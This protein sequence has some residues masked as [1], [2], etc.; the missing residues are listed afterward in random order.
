M[1][2][3]FLTILTISRK[4]NREPMKKF[5]LENG[6]KPKPHCPFYFDY[7]EER[8]DSENDGRETN[9]GQFNG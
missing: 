1:A 7:G 2:D 4:I 6:K 5:L 3:E 9:N 8:K